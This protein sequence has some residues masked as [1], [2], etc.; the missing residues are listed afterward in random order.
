MGMKKLNLLTALVTA[1]AL[2]TTAC[3]TTTPQQAKLPAPQ[4][5][6][7][8]IAP[9][10]APLPQSI[11]DPAVADAQPAHQSSRDAVGD[12]ITQAE[13]E[14]QKGE[15]RFKAGDLEE[16]KQSFD[17]AADLLLQSPPEIRS[18]E[19]VQ[20]ELEQVL[21]SVNRPELAALQVDSA[22]AKQKSEPAPID[23]T[24]EVTPPVD[25]NVKAQ[26]EA[27]QAAGGCAHASE[28]PA[29]RPP[30]RLREQVTARDVTCRNPACRQPAWR[31]D[32]DHTLDYDHGGRTCPCNLGGV[33]RG[34]HQLKQHPRWKLE[35]IRPG[36]FRWTTI[37]GRTYIAG[38]GIYDA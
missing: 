7:P 30:P 12:L 27:D 4:A 11:S 35:Q 13:R 31:A 23:E 20:H 34:D 19:R 24:N 21:E 33:C 10:L 17:K 36:V 29:Y 32:L 37:A 38:P 9:V 3:H 22:G 28:S 25:P 14:Y 8:A 18:D 5:N 1:L 6:A 15:E 16:S 2:A 26:A